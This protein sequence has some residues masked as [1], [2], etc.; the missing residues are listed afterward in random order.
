MQNYDKDVEVT[1]VDSQPVA[2]PPPLPAVKQEYVRQLQ[3][4]PVARPK[5]V[6]WAASGELAPPRLAAGTCSLK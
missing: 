4:Q 3:Q 1:L 2:P 5:S 6:N